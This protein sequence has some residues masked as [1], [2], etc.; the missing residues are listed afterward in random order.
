MAELTPETVM[1]VAREFYDY[2]MTAEAAAVVTKVAQA[3]LTDALRLSALGLEGVEPP[4]S[5]TTLIAEAERLR[6]GEPPS[7]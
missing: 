6:R 5:Y 7:T 4:F 2:P 1:R 3:M